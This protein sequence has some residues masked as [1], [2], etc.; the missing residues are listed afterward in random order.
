[1]IA[2]ITRAGKLLP[3]GAL[4]LAAG[5]RPQVAPEELGTV[6]FEVP[7]FDPEEQKYP[8]PK[9][10]EPPESSESTPAP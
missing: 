10:G 4:L 1:M 3:L 8:M 6:V 5:C 9:L 2:R 7:K